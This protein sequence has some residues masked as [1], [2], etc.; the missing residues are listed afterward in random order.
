MKKH[1]WVA[2][3]MA[4]AACCGAAQASGGVKHSDS[5]S[6]FY[7]RGAV[8][9]ASMRTA[10][11]MFMAQQ[12]GVT[13]ASVKRGGFTGGVS[14]GYMIQRHAPV[15]YGVEVGYEYLHSNTYLSHVGGQDV[16][17]TYRGYP[18]NL[19]AV[20]AYHFNLRLAL[21]GRAGIAWQYQS[22]KTSGMAHV[23]AQ[24]IDQSKRRVL[25]KVG[26]GLGY[27]FSSR[28]MAGVDYMHAFGSKQPALG[29]LVNGALP[30]LN[31]VASTDSVTLALTYVF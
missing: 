3:C 26:V 10:D 27:Y 13:G 23:A 4:C 21:F 30:E 1:N 14:L 15:S 9:V 20:L 25:P 19:L 11:D 16:T 6:G 29:A 7:V 12:A 28:W 5:G 8:G 22:V 18:I 17:L 31:K 24:D 2:A